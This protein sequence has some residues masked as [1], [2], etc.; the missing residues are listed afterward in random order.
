MLF[1]AVVLALREIRRNVLRSSLTTLGIVIGVGSVIVMV[2]LG[3][4]A[5]A[6]VTANIASLGSNLLTLNPGQRMGPGG[7]SGS[8]RPFQQRDV[9]LL[10]RDI[11]SLATVAPISSQSLTAILGGQNWS[12]TVT[13]TTNSYFESGNWTLASRPLV[14]RS[15]PEGREGRRHHRRDRP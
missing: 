9:D 5:T 2:T 14:H 3:N 7:A 8:A 11:P 10:A 13:G 1:N 15:R 12:T 6:M 4:G